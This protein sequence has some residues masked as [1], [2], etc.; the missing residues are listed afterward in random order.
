MLLKIVSGAGILTR[1]AFLP[2]EHRKLDTDKHNNVV[3]RNP[4]SGVDRVL[5]IFDRKSVLN[6]LKL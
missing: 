5:M 6:L 2:I 4:D 1:I 3:I